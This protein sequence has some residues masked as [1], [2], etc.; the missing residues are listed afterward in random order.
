M[1]KR[2]QERSNNACELCEGR[3][4][5]V[6]YSVPPKTDALIENQVVLCGSCQERIQ[7]NDY[8]DS[9]YFRFLTGSIW[10]ETPS[11][12][13]LSY[14]ILSKLLHIDW[15]A[16]TLENAYLDD[17]NLEWAKAE[18]TAEANRTVHKDA[19]GTELTTGDNIL[20]TQNL[21][22]KGTNFIAP[23]GTKVNKIRLV[24]DNEEHIEG[25]VNGKTIIILTKYVK[26]T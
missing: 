5:L 7:S 4:Q 17:G 11:V 1:Q 20:L 6:A 26:K 24:H 23:K 10:S 19:Y 9:N 2:L 16:E 8:S 12:Q 15:A 18:E 14:K 21:N 25:K 13:V 22:V 3:E